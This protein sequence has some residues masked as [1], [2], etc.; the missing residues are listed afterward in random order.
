MELIN[1]NRATATDLQKIKG[2]GKIRAGLIIQNRPFR[3]L[4]ELSKIAGL[5]KKRM[6]DIIKQ[7]EIIITL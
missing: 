4:Y 7:D 5:G 6:D 1:V 3:D 2:V